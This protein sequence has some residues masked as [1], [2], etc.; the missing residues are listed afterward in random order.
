MSWST[1]QLVRSSDLV[2]EIPCSSLQIIIF[3]FRPGRGSG[4]T[5]RVQAQPHLLEP[6]PKAQLI[7]GWACA[8]LGPVWSMSTLVDILTQEEYNK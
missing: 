1:A 2:W 7:V 8:G 4:F 5:T 6:K 3:I